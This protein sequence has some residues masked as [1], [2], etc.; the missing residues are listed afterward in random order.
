MVLVI[1]IPEGYSHECIVAQLFCFEP[2]IPSENP[3]LSCPA[4]LYEIILKIINLTNP[5]QYHVTY[6]LITAMVSPH[7]LQ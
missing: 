2:T 5:K 1:L 7:F 3:D 4:L 6:V